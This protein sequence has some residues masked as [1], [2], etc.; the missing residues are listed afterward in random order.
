MTRGH[1]ATELHVRLLWP[2]ERTPHYRAGMD[3]LRVLLVDDHDEYR[4]TRGWILA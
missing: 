1:A 3:G 4:P 2:D